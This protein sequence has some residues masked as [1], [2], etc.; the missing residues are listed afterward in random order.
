MEERALFMTARRFCRAMSVFCFTTA[1]LAPWPDRRASFS[2]LK[3]ETCAWARWG[4]GRGGGRGSVRTFS[5]LNR[6][7]AKRPSD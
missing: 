5:W 3:S 2:R 1:R 6:R 7:A 4:V